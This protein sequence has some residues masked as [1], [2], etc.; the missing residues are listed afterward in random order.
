MSTS[1]PDVSEPCQGLI[2]NLVLRCGQGDEA[3][4]GSLF[5]LTF[6]LVAAAVDRGTLSATGVDDE[7]V[8]VFRRIWGRSADYEPTERGV[9]AWVLDQVHDDRGARSVA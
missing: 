5:D 4:L 2:T 3:A 9:L 1:M 7:V 8:E 6:F